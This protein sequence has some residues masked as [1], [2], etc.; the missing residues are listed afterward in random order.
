MVLVKWKIYWLRQKRE[1]IW[2]IVFSQSYSQFNG[3]RLVLS[4]NCIETI[5]HPLGKRLKLCLNF[6][7]ETKVKMIQR[8]ECKTSKYKTLKRR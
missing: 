5:K 6:T 8:P 3:K 1:A 7:T 2:P 4:I